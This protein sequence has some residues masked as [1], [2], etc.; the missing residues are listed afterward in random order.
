[1]PWIADT[2]SAGCTTEQAGRISSRLPASG[3]HP[4]K[5]SLL[6]RSQFWPSPGYAPFVAGGSPEQFSWFPHRACEFGHLRKHQTCPISRLQPRGNLGCA[7]A[8]PAPRTFIVLRA[9]ASFPLSRTCRG[10]QTARCT[11]T[12]DLR[13]W[14]RQGSPWKELRITS[15]LRMSVA[16]RTYREVHPHGSI[17]R[18]PEHSPGSSGDR[19]RRRRWL[20]GRRHCY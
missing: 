12:N 16:D 14:L 4:H 2:R 7:G 5:L 1:M 20:L 9:C 15:G 6:L 19:K 3:D 10:S 17:N 18:R 8:R 11:C 13:I